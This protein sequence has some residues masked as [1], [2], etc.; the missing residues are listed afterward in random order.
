MDVKFDLP[1]G[2]A[3]EDMPVVPRIGEYLVHKDKLYVVGEVRW[4]KWTDGWMPILLLHP[5]PVR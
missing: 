1:D 4:E 3:L 5:M 2:V